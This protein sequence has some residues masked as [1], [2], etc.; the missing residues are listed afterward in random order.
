M[1][2][3]A[4]GRADLAAEWRAICRQLA[5]AQRITRVNTGC[6][7]PTCVSAYIPEPGDVRRKDCRGHVWESIPF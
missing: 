6:G 1:A 5:F 7:C 2:A 3:G 4:Q